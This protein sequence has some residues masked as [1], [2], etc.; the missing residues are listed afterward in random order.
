MGKLGGGELKVSSD[1]DLIFVYD[2]DG[3]TGRSVPTQ[4]DAPDVSPLR[5][6]T[7]HEFFARLGRRLIAL[8]NDWT[9]DGFVF[10]WTCA[11]VRMARPGRWLCPMGCSRNI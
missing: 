7:N 5:S 11:Y 3:E 10:R 6:I 4:A 1:I 2:E 9:A 8:L